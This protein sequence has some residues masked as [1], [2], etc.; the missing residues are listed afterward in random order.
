MDEF[1][2]V[3]KLSKNVKEKFGDVLSNLRTSDGIMEEQA[4]MEKILHNG[5]E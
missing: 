5:L 2:D 4:E 3:T 1:N